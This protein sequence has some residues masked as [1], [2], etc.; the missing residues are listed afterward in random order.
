MFRLLKKD[1]TH[2][3]LRFSNISQHRYIT[4]T[5]DI[6]HVG[7]NHRPVGCEERA[8]A[9]EGDDFH[10][11]AIVR[12]DAMQL[13]SASVL[14]CCPLDDLVDEL[15]FFALLGTKEEPDATQSITS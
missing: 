14:L 7:E 12:I 8:V 4:S 1:W 13:G 11:A 5:L 15:C 10:H 6:L 3:T 2:S 9:Q